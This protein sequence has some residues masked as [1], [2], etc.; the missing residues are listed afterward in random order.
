MTWR[1]GQTLFRKQT[2]Q[3][4]TQ[5]QSSYSKVQVLPHGDQPQRPGPHYQQRDLRLSVLLRQEVSTF[6]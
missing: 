6:N 3:D 2:Y 5:G 4:L 1:G